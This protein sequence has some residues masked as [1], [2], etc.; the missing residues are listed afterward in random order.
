MVLEGAARNWACTRDWTLP[1]FREK[2]GHAPILQQDLTGFDTADSR[3]QGAPEVR[4]LGAAIDEMLAG[5]ST[6]VRFGTVVDDHPELQEML[7][8]R[9]LDTLRGAS[10]EAF[11]AQL[12]HR[13]RWNHH[14]AP[15]RLPGQS[16]RDGPRPQAVDAVSGPCHGGSAARARRAGSTSTPT[17][18]PI[19]PTRRIP[20]LAYVQGQRVI[21]EPGDVLYNP[22]YMWHH[23]VNLSDS[24]GVGVRFNHV[25][26]TLRASLTL[27]LLRAL[28]WDP[29]PWVTLA[30]MVRGRGAI[31][32]MVEWRTAPGK[33]GPRV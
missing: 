11:G 26:S 33:R 7:D 31:R 14:P 19:R 24:I 4:T 28:A 10:S 12:L 3:W 13:P 15:C 25:P 27:P 23:V 1:W 5:H 8:R 2:Y 6:Y 29:P 20:A 32:S 17:P 9:W 22:P 16:V 21:L 30:A 18:T